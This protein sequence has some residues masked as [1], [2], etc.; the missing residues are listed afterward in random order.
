M[1]NPVQNMT[2]TSPVKYIPRFVPDL[3]SDSSEAKTSPHRM[4]SGRILPA[5]D[6]NLPPWS[7]GLRVSAGERPTL[8]WKQLKKRLKFLRGGLDSTYPEET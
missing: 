6:E 5:P 8:E 7:M 1:L 3:M 2:C 4:R